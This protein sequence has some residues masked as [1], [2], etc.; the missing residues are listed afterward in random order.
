MLKI[1][2]YLDSIGTILVGVLGGPDPRARHRPAGQPDLDVRAATAAAVGLRRAVRHRGGARSASCPASSAQIGFFRS[3]PNAELG[4][5]IALAALLV[6]VVLGGIGYYGFLPFYT[7]AD[8]TF[9]G[10]RP[11]AIAVLRRSSAT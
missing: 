2:I 9:F 10:E 7:G 3:R 11:T 4:H 5:S 6:V 8:F 1:P